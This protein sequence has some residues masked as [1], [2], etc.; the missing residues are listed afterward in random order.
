MPR[1]RMHT[2]HSAQLHLFSLPVTG[3][4]TSVVQ[5]ARPGLA[6]IAGALAVELMAAT[7]QVAS[8]ARL[9]PCVSPQE[10]ALP[11][12]PGLL[13]QGAADCSRVLS[14]PL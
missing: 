8:I 1:A 3:E 6:P 13:K 11:R 4:V 14:H 12:V 5:V 7:L 9:R 2:Q 10:A